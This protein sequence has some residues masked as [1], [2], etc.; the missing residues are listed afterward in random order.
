MKKEDIKTGKEQHEGVVLGEFSV[1][2]GC[3]RFQQG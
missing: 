3:N 2:G 1:H